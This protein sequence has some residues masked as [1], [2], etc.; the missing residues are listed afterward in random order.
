MVYRLAIDPSQ[1][2]DGQIELTSPQQHYLSRVLRL[3]SGDRFV[4]MDGRGKS[5]I[6]QLIGSSA[7]II[8]PLIELTELPIAVNLMTALPKGNGFEEIVRCGTELGATA[9][10]PLLSDRT[11]L[12]PSSHKLERWRKIATEAA[13]QS[14]R[15]VVPLIL[16]PIQFTQALKE[17]IPPESNCYICVTRTDATPLL[18]HLQNQPL[19][20]TF[21]A[22]GPEGGWTETEVAAAI[23]LGFCPVSLGRRI[24]RAITAPIAALSLVAAIAEQNYR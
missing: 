8:E 14:E 2:H 5:W 4:A 6:A 16:E 21:L 24:L 22:T 23:G 10:M 3:R 9:F 1:Q 13:E 18:V 15:Q 17:A 20:N 7:Q 19:K 12:N 11:L